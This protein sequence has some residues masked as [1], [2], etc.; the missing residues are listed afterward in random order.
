ME[1]LMQYVWQ[2]RLWPTHDMVTVDGE[3][4]VVLDPGLINHDAGPDFFNAKLLIGGIEWAGNI[5][6]HVRA[7]DW[8]RHHH[9]NDPAY[10]SVVLH[11]V[12]VN[13]KRITSRDGRVI[14]QMVMKC[15]PDFAM[16]YHALVNDPR[17]E[18]PCSNEIASLPPLFITEWLASL[19]ME[20]IYA[21]ADRIRAIV[22]ESNGDWAQAIYVTLARALGFNTNSQPLELLARSMP[23]KQLLHYTDSP[24]SVEA[25]LFGQAGMLE[26]PSSLPPYGQQLAQ[27]YNFLK[28]KHRLQRNTNIVWKMARMRPQNSPHRRIATLAA[29]VCGPTLT[30]NNIIRALDEKKARSLFDIMFNPFWSSHYHFTSPQQTTQ[31]KALSYTSVTVLLINVIIPVAVAYAIATGNPDRIEAAVDFLHQLKGETN[32]ITQTFERARILAADAFTSQAMIQLK[33]EYCDKRKCL[34]CRIGHRL[35]SARVKR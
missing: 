26:D 4:V 31:E 9:D 8:H 22:D 35:L 17:R 6:I 32:R 10:D 12:D 23:L 5:E 16:R 29:M 2:M 7:S 24:L 30:G 11:V 28:T 1:A 19:A 21:K 25:M 15:A 20:R 13:D 18:L 14:Q 33:N 27:E 34:L 3:R